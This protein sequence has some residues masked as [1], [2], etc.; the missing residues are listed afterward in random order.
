MSLKETI[1]G[2][3]R[4]AKILERSYK[5]R[6]L[7]HAYL[8][9]GPDYLGKKKL[10]LGFSELILGRNEKN[11]EN[12]LDLTILCPDK[13]SKQI[14]VEEIRY[15]E[16]K[17]SL[18]PYYSK[19]KIA[20]IEQADRMNKMAAN[21]LLK[22]LEEPNATAIIIL[23]TSNSGNIPDTIKSRCQIIKFFP[24]S[25]KL[26]K[27]T[28]AGK[29]SDCSEIEKIIEISA[30]KPEKALELASNGRKIEEL[31]ENISKLDV[32]INNCENRKIV[33]AAVVSEKELNEIINMLNLWIVCFRKSMINCYKDNDDLKKKCRLAELKKRIDI[34]NKTKKDLLT[35]NVSCKLAIENLFLNI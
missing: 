10:A 34:I 29:I 17:L 14:T 26:L 35:K 30:G 19:S 32:V 1:I 22:T 9:E 16:K 2:N 3:E 6:K 13:N 23:I 21:A 8:F 12:N 24:V 18:Y 28:L 15:L 11:V 7:A 5:N 33:E 25:E 27:K 4:A 31:I 20:I